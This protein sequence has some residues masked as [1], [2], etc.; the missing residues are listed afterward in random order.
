MAAERESIGGANYDALL[1]AVE[2]GATANELRARYPQF[3]SVIAALFE[4]GGLSTLE[5]DAPPVSLGSGEAPE[6]YEALITRLRGFAAPESRYALRSEVGRGGMGFVRRAFDRVMRR[7]VAFKAVHDRAAHPATPR[8]T[9]S[10]ALAKFLEEAQITGQLDHPGIVP[11]HDLGVD[12]SGHL[13]ITM[14]L[15]RGDDL[16]RVFAKISSGAE[17]WNL[18]RGL[19]VLQRVCEAMAFAHQR[20]VIHRDLKPANVM[21][22]EFGEV[23]VMDWGLARVLAEP[24]RR[25]IRLK[26]PAGDESA[27]GLY[28]RSDRLDQAGG[29]SALLTMDGDIATWLPNRRAATWRRSARA[30]TCIRSGRCSTTCSRGASL[31]RSPRRRCR[32]RSCC[33]AF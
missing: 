25:D 16:T 17:D 4:A 2:S 1:A 30:P 32:R 26:A 29:G 18:S 11:V 27:S 20:G 31:S 23:Y 33:I 13:F 28:V 9:D 22:G 6:D 3:E 7:S 10:R 19:F 24:D 8:A 12:S 5:P 21:V 14:K 15:V